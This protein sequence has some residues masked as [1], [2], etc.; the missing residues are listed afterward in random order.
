VIAAESSRYRL[1]RL[2]SP[3]PRDH[4]AAPVL[5][6][7]TPPGRHALKM[8]CMV[9]DPW[10]SS[11]TDPCHLA[12]YH[13]TETIAELTQWGVRTYVPERRQKYDRHWTDRPKAHEAAFR[14]NRRRVRGARSATLL[15][16]QSHYR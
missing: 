6:V 16:I 12:G 7:I 8:T 14:A 15:V 13:R 3:H 1:I 10:H 4:L 2:A 5:L 11:A 9:S